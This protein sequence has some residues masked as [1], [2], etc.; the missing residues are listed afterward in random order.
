MDLIE[1]PSIVEAQDILAVHC[2]RMEADWLRCRHWIEDA[3]EHDGGLYMIEDI[4]RIIR[5]G[6]AHFWAGE[7]SAA[8]TQWWHFPR[9]KVLN[10]WLA[11]GDLE[12]LTSRMFPAAEQ[13]AAKRGATRIMLAGR[14][15]WRKAM[16]PHGFGPLST[17][18]IK[19]IER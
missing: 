17:L 11:G 14:P 18:L 9:D 4:E 16:A 5:D 19:E 7:R 13:W 12:E 10:L 3:L 2:G 15:G 1:L 6:E 8:V